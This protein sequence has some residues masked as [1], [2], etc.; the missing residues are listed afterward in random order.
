M[1]KNQVWVYPGKNNSQNSWFGRYLIDPA[2]IKICWVALFFQQFVSFCR[3]DGIIDRQFVD[4]MR[5][6]VDRHTAPFNEDGRVMVFLI[7]HECDLIREL[8]RLLNSLNVNFLTR[9]NS[10]LILSIDQPGS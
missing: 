9:R 4:Q 10:P 2:F 6:P 1:K 7:S 8:D 5:P 3:H